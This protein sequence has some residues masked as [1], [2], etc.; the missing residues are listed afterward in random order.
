MRYLGHFST[1]VDAAV[2]YA[3]FVT[4]SEEFVDPESFKLHGLPLESDGLRLYLSSRS[5][6]GYLGVTYRPLYHST[7]PYVARGPKPEKR[8]LGYFTTAV[9]AATSYAKF[10]AN[11]ISEGVHGLHDKDSSNEDSGS[12]SDSDSDPHFLMHN[13]GAP[14]PLISPDLPRS[15]PSAPLADLVV[16]C[17]C[18]TKTKTA[19]TRAAA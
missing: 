15:P 6:A 10:V 11:R 5:N 7:R 1:P 12:G 14:S 19:T 4:S 8:R 17:S 16:A 3:K 9:E 18:T 13:Q 2:A